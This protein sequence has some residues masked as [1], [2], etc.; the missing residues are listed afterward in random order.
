MKNDENGEIKKRK[1]KTAAEKA[2]EPMK[3]ERKKRSAKDTESY[4]YLSAKI[5]DNIREQRKKLDMSQTEL[6]DAVN[7]TVSFLSDI[8]HHRT[9]P[10]VD[11]F[12]KI[13]RYLNITPILPSLPDDIR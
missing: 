6:A 13:C 2:A 9:M 3:K 4:Q 5:G 12:V 1:T 11:T 10:S 8:E 7:I